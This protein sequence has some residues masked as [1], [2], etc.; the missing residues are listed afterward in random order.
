MQA[1]N[2]GPSQ[3]RRALKFSLSALVTSILFHVL[4][5]R[6]QAIPLFMDDFESGL[7]AWTGKGF[8]PHNGITVA[9]PL[10]SGHGM[11]LTFT[12]V[13]AAGDIFTSLGTFP[14]GVTISFDYLGL[15]NPYPAGGFLGISEGTPGD[16]YWLAGQ[17]GYG[18]LFADL[19]DDG[20]WHHYDILIPAGGS[21]FPADPPFRLMIEDFQDSSPFAGDAFFD[22]ITVTSATVPDTGPG[23]VVIVATVLGLCVAGAGRR[24]RGVPCCRG[25]QR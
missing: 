5:A 18:G 3:L 1:T 16:H 8:G 24:M 22:N 25:S 9:D 20:A 15:V 10:A 2:L 23:I 19:V 12:A 7:G 6:V 17:P 11:V 13:N 21:P 4:V 14:D